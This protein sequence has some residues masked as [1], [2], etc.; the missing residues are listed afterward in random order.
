MLL[1][2]G[3]FGLGGNSPPGAANASALS[4]TGFYAAGGASATNFFDNYSP[5]IMVH[6]TPTAGAQI[7]PTTSGRLAV[8]GTGGSSWTA[9]N[10][11]WSTG[12]T[13]VDTNNF[14]KKAS[15]IARLT[16]DVGEMQND[17]AVDEQH[18]ISG[19][20]SVNAEAEGVSADKA[21]TGVY[22][23]KG[24]SGM[25]D[26]GWTLEVPQDINGNRLC[27][28]E[29]ATDKEGV[30]TVS[31]FKRRFDVDSAMIVA[32]E[33]MDIPEGRW[34]DLRLQMPED[35]AWNTRMREM[36]QAAEGEEQTS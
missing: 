25:A 18:I 23:V 14:I 32:G 8:R 21:A 1:T 31:V 15:P 28:V 16:N 9:W 22:V 35:S 19:L 5:L 2:A 6:R 20:V 30:I 29:L 33:P 4:T 27:F 3:A 17:F 13:T 11:M 24:A 12:N 36:E 10:E 34:I 26:E 7:Q